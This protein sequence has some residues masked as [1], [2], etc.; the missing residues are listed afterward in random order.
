M[1]VKHM[2]QKILKNV[3]LVSKTYQHNIL[4]H[5][6]TLEHI[7]KWFMKNYVMLKTW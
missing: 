3:V 4:E 5:I 6:R 7:L 1:T 2:L